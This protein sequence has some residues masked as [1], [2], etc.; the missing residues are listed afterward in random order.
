MKIVCAYFIFVATAVTFAAEPI[1]P[2]MPPSPIAEFRGWLKK[3]PQER[4]VALA[5]RS[6]KSRATLESKLQEYSKMPE[7]ERERRLGALELRWYLRQLL[8]MTPARRAEALASVPDPWKPIVQVRL[9]QWDRIP[10]ELQKEV[11]AHETLVQF[12]STPAQQRAMILDSLSSEERRALEG[13]VVRWKISPVVERQRLDNRLGQFFSLDSEK[14]KQTL[15]QFS[16]EERK[17]METTL[18]TFRGLTPEQRQLCINSFSKFANMSREE[19]MT[20]L[21]NAERWQAMSQQERETWRQVV[22]IAPPMPVVEAP[23]PPQPH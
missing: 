16:D 11:L 20:F 18:Q 9:E 13:R 6:E 10:A 4:K 22:A 8:M 23:V 7:A 12:L 1:E 5:R 14:Q 17:E 2:P 21:K 15:D 19:Q 3:S